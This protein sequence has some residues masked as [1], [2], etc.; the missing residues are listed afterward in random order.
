M[1]LPKRYR[2][3]IRLGVTNETFDTERRPHRLR[4][5]AGRARSREAVSAAWLRHRAD[6][7]LLSAGQSA[8]C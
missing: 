5:D 7:P 3:T 8:A 1:E 4:S 6:P 2:T